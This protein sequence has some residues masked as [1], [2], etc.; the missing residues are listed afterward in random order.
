M[1]YV[2]STSAKVHEAWILGS[3]F[4]ALKTGLPLFPKWSVPM[5][6][7][8]V[9]FMEM[10][11]AWFLMSKKGFLQKTI[12]SIFVFFHLYSGILV[13][14]RYP[15]TILPTLLILFGPLYRYSPPPM[16]KKSVAGW[17]LVV[18]L[19][20]LQIIPRAIPGDEKL[21]GEGN[22]FG[23]YMFDSNHQCISKV[24]LFGVDGT[25]STSTQTSELARD[26]CDPYHTWFR[27]HQICKSN[28]RIDRIAWTFDHSING[29][30]FLRIVDTPD[31]CVLEYRPFVH[32]KWIRSD[33][34]T[35]R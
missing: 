23:L 34:N 30:P 1:L 26:R 13:E 27:L 22:K 5:W 19:F 6:T 15:A 29:G 9:I 3:Y 31:A 12:L 8:S 16:G 11:G 33:E 14:Y 28:Q 7:N 10:I 24:A 20:S 17:L 4:T 32:N 35:H 2:L 25:I 21:T 18:T